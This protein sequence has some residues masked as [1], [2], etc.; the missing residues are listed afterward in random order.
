M[1]PMASLCENAEVSAIIIMTMLS[2]ELNHFLFEFYVL[3]TSKV[4][5]VPNY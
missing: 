4:I 2:P 5:Q 3:A 1:T